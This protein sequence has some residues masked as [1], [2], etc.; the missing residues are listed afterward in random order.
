MK[1]FLIAAIAT[2][3]VAS[4]ILAAAPAE[5]QSRQTERTVKYKPNGKVVVKQRTTVQ[6]QNYRQPV[7]QTYRTNWRKGE[8]FDRRQARNYRQVSNWREYQNR[9]LY[10]PQRG[11]QWV[12]S[13]NDAVLITVASGVIGAVLAGAFN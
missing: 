6:R 7:R 9:R 2:T 1:K 8:R 4:P 12:R 5:A 11:Q 10:A 13:G 3:L